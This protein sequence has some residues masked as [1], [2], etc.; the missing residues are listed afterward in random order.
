MSH[1]LQVQEFVDTSY[2]LPLG[3]KALS[4]KPYREKFEELQDSSAH[5]HNSST[6]A[7]LQPLSCL[8][9][10]IGSTATK[11]SSALQQLY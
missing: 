6:E 3:L 10:K 9:D 8:L 11:A 4:T 2:N 1:S 7:Y 5:N